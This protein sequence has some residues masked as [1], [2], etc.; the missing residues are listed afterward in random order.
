MN[1]EQSDHD[2]TRPT[3][4]TVRRP[5]P[6][7]SQVL[8]KTSVQSATSWTLLHFVASRRLRSQDD[9]WS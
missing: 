9:G 2:E 7:S 1:R 5:L 8:M 6:I 4:F 3:L